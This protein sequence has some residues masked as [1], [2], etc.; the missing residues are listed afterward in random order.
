LEVLTEK[1][2]EE[3]AKKYPDAKASLERWLAETKKASWKSLPD[4]Q[5]TFPQVSYILQ[6]QYCF[7]I[8]G[9]GYRLE[10]AISFKLQKVQV[11][12]FKTHAE[13]DKKNKTRR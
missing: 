6:N 8:Q 2:I 10:T 11:L 9:G 4:I 12:D 3:F 1:E 5:Q 13:H 7:N